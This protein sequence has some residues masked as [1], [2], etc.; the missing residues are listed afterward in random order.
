MPH[1]HLTVTFLLVDSPSAQ[2]VY[3]IRKAILIKAKEDTILVQVSG[4][5]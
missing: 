2:F 3:M 5:K 4:G 1:N